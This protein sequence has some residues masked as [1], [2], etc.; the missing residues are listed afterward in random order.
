MEK[1]AG[2]PASQGGGLACADLIIFYRTYFRSAGTSKEKNARD[3]EDQ[4]A[5]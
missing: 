3:G 1:E 5:G 4:R 2:G